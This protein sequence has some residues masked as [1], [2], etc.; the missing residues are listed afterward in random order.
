MER[1]GYAASV[2][3]NTWYKLTSKMPFM[4][5]TAGQDAHSILDLHGLSSLHITSGGRLW[6]TLSASPVSASKTAFTCHAYL[7][8]PGDNTHPDIGIRAIKDEVELHLSGAKAI[9]SA[10]D[11]ATCLQGTILL[12]LMTHLKAERKAGKE[13]WPARREP[14]V[15]EKYDRADLRKFTPCSF[16]C[17]IPRG[18][19]IRWLLRRSRLSLALAFFFELT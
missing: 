12:E 8:W 16:I 6:Y 17:L 4:S 13:L 7:N 3:P 19:R 14:I 5:S 15:S 10:L 2:V 11:G 9:P 18:S 1:S